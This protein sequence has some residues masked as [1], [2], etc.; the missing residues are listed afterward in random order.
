MKR[1]S[2]LVILI[3]CALVSKAQDLKKNEFSVSLG[4]M[5]EGE[6]YA[7]ELDQ[8]YSVGET[9]LIRGEFDHYFSSMG[10]RFGIGG[11]YTLGF[12]FYSYFYEE[13]TM[14]EL[15][16]VL[17]ARFNASDQI[18]IKPGIYTGY[19]AYTG[20]LDA[21]EDPGTGFGLNATVSFQYELNEKLKPF[22]DLG[23][24]TQPAGGND[25]TDIT[26]SPTFQFSLG[27][28]F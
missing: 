14:H 23:I 28:T 5:F 20:G 25:A 13:V 7:A 26:Y 10:D 16:L 27:V 8:Y 22:I 3:S 9:I 1:L 24:M 2:V 4:Y 18:Q 6:M 15:G 19:R 21:G 12:P 17:K 11:Y